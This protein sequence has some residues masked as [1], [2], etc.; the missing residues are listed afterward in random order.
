M[1]AQGTL[2]WG[3]SEGMEL[4]AQEGSTPEQIPRQPCPVAF[5]AHLCCLEE[6]LL[7]PCFIVI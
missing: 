4:S 7:H 1:G 5:G 3:T 2:L 6:I